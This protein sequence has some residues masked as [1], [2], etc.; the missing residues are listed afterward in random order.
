MQPATKD[1]TDDQF[2][3]RSQAAE[4]WGCGRA[5]IHYH[6]KTGNLTLYNIGG[7][8]MISIPELDALKKAIDKRK[9]N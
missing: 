7:L 8:K 5:N 1:L 2:I 9:G 3:T 4:R 6:L